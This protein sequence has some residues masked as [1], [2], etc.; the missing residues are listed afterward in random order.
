MREI[1]ADALRWADHVRP[2]DLVV[3]GQACAEPT[4]LTEGLMAGR[5]A[6]GGRFSVFVGIGFA[7]TLRPEHA[8]VVDVRSYCA[9]GGNR[10]LVAA[11]R[12]DILP[13]H[14]SAL[15]RQIAGSADVLLLQLAPTGD[16]DR[17]SFGL[18]CDYLQPAVARART[19]I[20][21]VNDQVPVTRSDWTITAEEIDVVVRTSRSP[22]LAP[23]AP[24][25]P[26]DAAIAANV[27][28]LV[29]DGATLQVGLGGMPAAVVDALSGHRDLGVHSGLLNPSLVRLIASG[30]V[31]NARKG[32]A[33][34]ASVVG[35]IAGDVETFRFCHDNPEIKLAPTSYTHDHDVLAR[36]PAFTAINAAIEVDL[37]GQINTEVAGSRYVGAVGGATD[38]LRGAAA[39][40][41]GLPIVALPSSIMAKD[42]RRVGRIVPRL[43]GPATIARADAGVI[44][45]EFGHADL[46]GRTDRERRNALIAIAHPELREALERAGAD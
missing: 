23:A 13:S 43:S 39:S 7:E 31:T 14:Y 37:A 28:D 2:G 9:T 42:G 21:E 36:L 46:R 20:A 40:D 35:L 5:H 17:F 10:R 29:P 32:R 44:V 34:S 22:A 15:S 4:T 27:A 38:F 26:L 8:D 12:L 25:G 1:A 6:I 11:G 18:A 3:W 24:A 45:T 16:P 19:V 33:D 41:G 30:G